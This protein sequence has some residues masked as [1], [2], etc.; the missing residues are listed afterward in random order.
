MAKKILHIIYFL[1]LLVLPSSCIKDGDGDCPVVSHTVNLVIKDKNYF[2]VNSFP[3]VKPVDE[4]LP[5]RSF[6][7]NIYYLLINTDTGEITREAALTD[8][9]DNNSR[10]TINLDD[11]PEGNYELAVWGNLTTDTPAGTL[12]PNGVEHTDIYVADALLKI[13]PTSDSETLYMQRTKG[14]LLVLC[15]NFPEGFTRLQANVKHISQTSDAHLVYGGD[16]E[17]NKD[18][19]LGSVNEM[20]LAPTPAGT[21]TLLNLTFYAPEA[22]SA[23]LPLIIPETKITMNRNEL[24]AIR[25]DYNNLNQ[26]WD[27]SIYADGKWTLIHH[28]DIS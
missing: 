24:T 1:I 28:L 27:V 25:V 4:Q 19:P 8:V 26:T 14:K 15:T 18:Q 3:E 9:T 7:S 6:S 23:T 16:A 11:I 2:N 12:H 10:Y 21:S 17:V 22:R 5:F 13:G 20:L